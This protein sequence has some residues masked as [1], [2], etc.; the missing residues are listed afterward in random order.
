MIPTNIPDGEPFPSLAAGAKQE[1]LPV[2]FA[3]TAHGNCFVET[4]WEP[5][6]EE[7]ERILAGRKIRVFL[8]TSQ[9][10][11]IMVEVA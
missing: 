7:V 2:R 10:P 5:T 8:L 11:P 6:K 1:V 9:Q 4:A 3:R